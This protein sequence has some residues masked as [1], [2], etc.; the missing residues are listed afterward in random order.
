[1]SKLDRGGIG[2]LIVEH[3]PEQ[4]QAWHRALRGYDL[5][6]ALSGEEGLG[7][8]AEREVDL[9]IVEQ[10]LPHV[11]GARV[12]ERLR[13]VNPLARRVMTAYE[14]DA[15]MLLEAL[16][17]GQVERYL[18][19]PLAPET[20][21]RE[22]DLLAREYEN[23]RAVRHGALFERRRLEETKEAIRKRERRRQHAQLAPPSAADEPARD[24]GRG[25][26][27]AVM[28]RI[29]RELSRAKRYKRPLSLL[30]VDDREGLDRELDAFLRYSDLALRL[31]S[32]LVLVLPETN[33]A[34]VETLRRRLAQAFPDRSFQATTFPDDGIE[35]AALL[36]VAR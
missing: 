1:L 5:I 3:D 25:G 4:V 17:R 8:L 34:G 31:E 22:I 16:N 9:A 19:K 36:A 32:R 7:V 26:P 12:L 20:M 33:A 27:A 29:E 35:L 18:L 2:V 30:L 13:T 24:E 6:A 14:P 11:S 21:R 15:D 23:L 10:R 28:L